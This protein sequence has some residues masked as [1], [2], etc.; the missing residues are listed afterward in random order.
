MQVKEYLQALSDDSKIHVEKI[1]SGNWY[2]SFASEETALRTTELAKLRAEMDAATKAVGELEEKIAAA[3]AERADGE[4][5]G[6][7][8]ML[9]TNQGTLV[10]EIGTLKKELASYADADR[11][12]VERKNKEVEGFKATAERWTDNLMLLDGYLNKL[13]GGNKEGMD[14][15]R[16]E[17]YGAEYVEGEGLAEL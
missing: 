7:R 10:E 5:E 8:E 1:G 15:L 16:R 11:G 17:C 13:M 3:R 6:E 2:W 4:E 9:L 12:E 14:G